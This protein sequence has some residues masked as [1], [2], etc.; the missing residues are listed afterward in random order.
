M[1][2]RYAAELM[3][4]YSRRMSGRSTQKKAIC[5]KKIYSIFADTNDEAYELA[6]EKGRA[7]EF[8]FFDEP[9]DI[10]YNFLGV[11]ELIS[12]DDEDD[13][14]MWSSFE[15]RFSPEA[16]KNIFVPDKKDLKIF[17]PMSTKGKMKLLA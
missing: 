7:E 2:K 14:V 17:M 3:F 4:F 9:Y 16:R 1:K 15:E 8:D 12:L 11:L 13:D 10:S 6:I 5:E